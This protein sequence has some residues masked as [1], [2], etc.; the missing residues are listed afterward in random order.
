MIGTIAITDKGWYEFLAAHPEIQEVNFWRPSARRPFNAPDFSPFLFKLKS[1]HKVI[2]GFGYYVTYSQLPSWL[3][4]ETFGQGNGTPTRADME[5]RLETIRKRIGYV[6]DGKGDYVGCTLIVQPVFFP[7]EAWIPQPQDWRDRVLTDMKYDLAAG[8]GRRVWEACRSIALSLGAERQA[9]LL[10]PRETERYGSPVSV[11]PR[12]G[13]RTFRIAVLDAYGRS[14]AVTS[15][16]S[17][18]ALEASHIQP[19]ADGGLHAVANGVLLRADIHR[20]F[21]KGYVTITPDLRLLVSARLR[22]EFSNGKTYYP[23][24]GGIVRVPETAKHRP[25]PELLRWH[26]DHTFAA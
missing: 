22:E 12:L 23:M 26:N 6:S 17:L 14:C 19:Y 7:P 2:C 11:K 24:D 25:D 3:A 21:D 13:Q 1:P 15:E 18:P 5:S 20:L 9:A 16:H 4:W 10:E 8:E